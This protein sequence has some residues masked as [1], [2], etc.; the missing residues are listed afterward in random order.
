MDSTLLRFHCKNDYAK[1]PLVTL[2]VNGMPVAICC[3][4]FIFRTLISARTQQFHNK[5]IQAYSH[6]NRVLYESLRYHVV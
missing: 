1:A 6:T 5:C 4:P 3:V 2:Y